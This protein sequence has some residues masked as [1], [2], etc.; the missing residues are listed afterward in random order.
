MGAKRKRY[1]PAYR[2]DA[3]HLVSDTGRPIAHVANEI[4]VGEQLLGRWV[5]SSGPSWLIHLR[6]WMS[7]SGPNWTG[8]AARSPSFGWTGSS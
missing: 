2:R 1:T 5:A 6:R 7:M 3:A 8:C 4:G